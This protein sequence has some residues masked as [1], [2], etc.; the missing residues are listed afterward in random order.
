[1]VSYRRTRT[2][3][4]TWLLLKKKKQNQIKNLPPT[5][6]ISVIDSGCR[7]SFLCINH[8][9]DDMIIDKRTYLKHREQDT[10][11]DRDITSFL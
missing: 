7:D 1:M 5:G 3:Q 9:G 10:E 2:G 11:H 8:R 4:S 6:V